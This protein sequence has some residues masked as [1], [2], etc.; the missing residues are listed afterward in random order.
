[1]R[2]KGSSENFPYSVK[3]DYHRFDEKVDLVPVVCEEG[4]GLIML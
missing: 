1:M 2:R 4:G 3:E